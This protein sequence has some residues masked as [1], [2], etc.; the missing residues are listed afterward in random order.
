MTFVG[1][2]IYH[3]LFLSK[4]LLS[5]RTTKY[6]CSPMA[7]SSFRSPIQF[8]QPPPYP[9]DQRKTCE[10]LCSDNNDCFYFIDIQENHE[11]CMLFPDGHIAPVQY[12]NLPGFLTVCKKGIT[13]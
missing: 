9:A 13:S 8:A 3:F 4:F 10:E 1:F 7:L 12:P 6:K 5:A 11:V 2:G